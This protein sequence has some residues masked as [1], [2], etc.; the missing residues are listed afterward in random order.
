[1]ITDLGLQPNNP[2]I[3]TGVDS[4][5]AVHSW[6]KWSP[7][8][9]KQIFMESHGMWI[10]STPLAPF[11]WVD[12]LKVLSGVVDVRTNYTIMCPAILGMPPPGTT[13]ALIPRQVGIYA[14]ISFSIPGNQYQLA[15]ST[16]SSLGL[17][18][19]DPCYEM[20]KRTP[21]KWHTMGQEIAFTR[22]RTLVVATTDV[23]PNNWQKQLHAFADISSIQI[24]IQ[25]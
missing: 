6:S 16:V 19:A 2:C 9:D 13:I 8:E 7:I 3:Q 11:D 5:G 20:S 4:Q 14:R 12:R 24:P 25:C 21:G 23:S 10:A 22:T 17:R 18:L 1:L 15:L